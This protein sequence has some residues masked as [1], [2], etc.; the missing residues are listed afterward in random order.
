V[1]SFDT[2]FDDFEDGVL[3]TAIWQDIASPAAVET[4]GYL[5]PGWSGNSG[6]QPSPNNNGVRSVNYYTAGDLVIHLQNPASA[7]RHV[8]WIVSNS[9]GWVGLVLWFYSDTQLNTYAYDGAGTFTNVGSTGFTYQPWIKVSWV[10]ATILNLAQSTDGSTWSNVANYDLTNAAHPFTSPYRLFLQGDDVSLRARYA[11]INDQPQKTSITAVTATGS[12]RTWAPT[13]RF[14]LSLGMPTTIGSGTAFAPAIGATSQLPPTLTG[15]G[16]LLPPTRTVYVSFDVPAATASGLA[17]APDVLAPFPTSIAAPTATGS[18]LAYAADAN[19]L[20]NTTINVPTM[21]GS[22]LTFATGEYVYLNIPVTKASGL[23]YLP[24]RVGVTYSGYAAFVLQTP[25]NYEGAFAYYRMSDQTSTMQDGVTG[26]FP[27]TWVGTRQLDTGAIV[28]DPDQS[29]LFDNATTQG[30]IGLPTLPFPDTAVLTSGQGCE[31]WFKVPVGQTTEHA[32]VARNFEFVN[33]YSMYISVKQGYLVYRQVA[34][35][36]YSELVSSKKVNDN[37]WHQVVVTQGTDLIGYTGYWLGDKKF[38]R[39]YVDGVLDQ[40][41]EFTG[42]WKNDVFVGAF[43]SISFF[44][45]NIDEL[46]WYNYTPSRWEVLE[47]WLQGTGQG[48]PK[49]LLSPPLVQT[50]NAMP[51]PTIRKSPIIPLN[52][53]HDDFQFLDLQKWRDQR[54][55]VVV[56]GAVRLDTATNDRLL[57]PDY[58]QCK[59]STFIAR[60]D[61]IPAGLGELLITLVNQND[62]DLGENQIYRPPYGIISANNDMWRLHREIGWRISR[63][64]L[65]GRTRTYLEA[66]SIETTG[67][68]GSKIHQNV[69]DYI[70]DDPNNP[71][72]MKWLKLSIDPGTNG[73]ATWYYS[74]DGITWKE[75]YDIHGGQVNTSTTTSIKIG[76]DGSLSVSDTTTV[77]YENADEFQLFKTSLQYPEETMWRGHMRV[78]VEAS[79]N[80]AAG[81]FFQIDNINVEPQGTGTDVSIAA[82]T[83]LAYTSSEYDYLDYVL[84]PRHYNSAQDVS[85]EAVT[86]R[87]SGLVP[88]QPTPVYVFSATALASGRAPDP[89]RGGQAIPILLA[90]SGPLVATGLVPVGAYGGPAMPR[91][92]ELTGAITGYG[93]FDAED[94]AIYTDESKPAP[95]QGSRFVKTIAIDTRPVLIGVTQN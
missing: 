56:D 39:L 12:G 23:A 24:Q 92:L 79:G 49:L 21:Q 44:E 55:A 10:S 61:K 84:A 3:N 62:M 31:V 18:G 13:L 25:Q 7:P 8:V 70:P 81:A 95:A 47:H 30:H 14:T 1:A 38:Q 40:Q 4:G 57:T 73:G 35:S 59:D 67:E 75:M 6:G 26:Q 9:T 65:N 60:V 54:G 89:T 83:A 63:Q 68:N 78:R 48:G 82:A 87:G 90:V 32:I 72:P 2:L 15:S 34:G 74:A 45:G 28:N 58:F 20:I 50:T 42:P 22:G 46:S 51:L 88:P 52:D 85:V 16:L 41:A 64:Q 5:Q 94:I 86:A 19:I 36:D 80:T 37:Q 69:I 71:S 93:S 53:F 17:Y 29:M 77:T 11:G 76:S 91:V 27:G 43:N 33:E 66:Y